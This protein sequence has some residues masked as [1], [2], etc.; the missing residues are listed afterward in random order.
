VNRTRT[1]VMHGPRGAAAAV[2]SGTGRVRR[3]GRASSS[4]TTSAIA[5]RMARLGDDAALTTARAAC[6][7]AASR[8]STACTAAWAR[9]Q[10]QRQTG[11]R[12]GARAGRHGYHYRGQR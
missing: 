3:S 12:Q 2:E 11:V 7:A 10:H 1:D 5:L 4:M 8:S 6:H 9:L